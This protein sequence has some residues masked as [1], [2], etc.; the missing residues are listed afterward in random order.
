MNK[1]LSLIFFWWHLQL[2]YFWIS[3]IITIISSGDRMI[4]TLTTLIIC[5]KIQPQEWQGRPAAPPLRSL[6]QEVVSHTLLWFIHFLH[7]SAFISHAFPEPGLFC[8][9]MFPVAPIFSANVH[10]FSSLYSWMKFLCVSD[11]RAL[12]PF[13]CWWSS[14]LDSFLGYCEQFRNALV[15]LCGMFVSGKGQQPCS[16]LA[17]SATWGFPSHLLGVPDSVLTRICDLDAV[18][19]FR[20]GQYEAKLKIL[21]KML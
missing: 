19:Y 11:P 12:Y 10:D 15:Y 16:I 14:R 1:N 17:P 13:V 2:G 4:V 9:T 8:L 5:L 18:K 21:L 7:S 20:I 6:G 3:H